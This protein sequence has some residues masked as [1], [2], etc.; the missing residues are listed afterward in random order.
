MPSDTL[1][2]ALKP[3]ASDANSSSSGAPAPHL[4]SPGSEGADRSKPYLLAVKSFKDAQDFS[5]KPSAY[6]K[7]RATET[8][9]HGQ[10]GQAMTVRSNAFEE[11]KVV[12]Q[13]Y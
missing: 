8:V 3:P 6:E 5:A 13:A 2:I 7:R 9:D 11:Q 10:I 12:I 4:P 1:S